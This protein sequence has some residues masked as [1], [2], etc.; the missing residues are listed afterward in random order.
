MKIGVWIDNDLSSSIG[1]GFSYYDTLIRA[2]DQY[3]FNNAE[4]CFVSDADISGYFQKETLTLTKKYRICLAWRLF[5]KVPGI[6]GVYARKITEE[7]EKQGE[8]QC[9]KQLIEHGISILYYPKGWQYKC[10]NFPYIATH[11]DIGHR[12]SYIF[13][14]FGG[15]YGLN[16]RDNVHDRI[17]PRALAIFAESESGKRELIKYTHINESRIFVIPIFAGSVAKLS[18]LEKQ[19]REILG[20]YK[21]ENTGYFFYPAQFWAHKNHVNLLK[22]FAA[23]HKRYPSYKLVLTGS[24]QGNKNYILSLIDKL[25]IKKSVLVL[26][27]VDL[28]EIY[29][30]YKHTTGLVMPTYLGPTNMPPLEAIELNCPVACTDLPGHREMLGDAA[31]YF[32]AEDVQGIESAM[33]ELYINNE[34]WRNKVAQRKKILPF[35]VDNAVREM[36]KAFEKIAIVRSAWA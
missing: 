19:Q 21:L 11:W 16:I 25:D 14:D 36:D 30:L 5:A 24:D 15:D 18:V 10:P 26:G 20:R 31:I 17:L 34:E 22:A 8:Y 29:T 2:I 28:E 13:P 27:F 32:K 3:D 33:E 1:G 9:T 35:T 6:R 4:I 7:L 23:F 12:S